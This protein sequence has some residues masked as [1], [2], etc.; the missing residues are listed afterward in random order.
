MKFAGSGYL[1]IILFLLLLNAWQRDILSFSKTNPCPDSVFIQLSGDVKTPGVFELCKNKKA[2]ILKR[3][4]ISSLHLEKEL[5][6]KISSCAQLVIKRRG[7]EVE[8]DIKPM[9]G[10]YRVTLG[11]PIC[12]NSDGE[13]DLIALPG[14]GPSLAKAIVR[15]REMRGEFHTLEE[16]MHIKGIS[17]RRFQ[18]ILPYLT[19][20]GPISDK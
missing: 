16:L 2:D 17:R 11:F 8:F 7:D 5:K 6:E 15:E 18:R 3:A 13:E 9:S 14:I 1:P 19:L 4:G 20:N 10:F 12:I